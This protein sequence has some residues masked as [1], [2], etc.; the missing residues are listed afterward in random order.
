MSNG[1]AITRTS[2]GIVTMSAP[3]NENMTTMVNNSAI[4]VPGEMLGMNFFSYQSRTL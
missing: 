1:N 3:F 2:K 4:S